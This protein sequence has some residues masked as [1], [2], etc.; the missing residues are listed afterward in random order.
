MAHIVLLEDDQLLGSA[1]R[2]DLAA[3]GNSVR[4]TRSVPECLTVLNDE[5]CDLLITEFF[6]RAGSA[7]SKV[8]GATI[9]IAI[10]CAGSVKNGLNVDPDLP[11]IV[12]DGHS[13]DGIALEFCS[14]LGADI[15][16]RLPSKRSDLLANVEWLLPMERVGQSAA[17]SPFG[18]TLG[19]GVPDT[20]S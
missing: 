1:M 6:V 2:D 15:T 9:V 18:W 17:S 4:V 12:L 7:F 19:T 5:D 11:I 13:R 16:M 14:M 20:R 8:S 3:Q 10:R